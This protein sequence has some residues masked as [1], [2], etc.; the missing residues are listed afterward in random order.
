MSVP[1]T[2]I[3]R[4]Q[5]VVDN[6]N[7]IAVRATGAAL[8]A[9]EE[10]KAA[11]RAT[12]PTLFIE[13]AGLLDSVVFAVLGE[14]NEDNPAVRFVHARGTIEQAQAEA[15]KARTFLAEQGVRA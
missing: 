15:D 7:A 8:L 3:E 6:N 14:S 12:H 9:L 5:A 2:E 13:A 4:L 11:V 10:I 1:L